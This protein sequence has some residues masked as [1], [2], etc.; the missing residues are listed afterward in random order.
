[1]LGQ[2]GGGNPQAGRDLAEAHA[3]GQGQPDYFSDLAHGNVGPGHRHLLGSRGGLSETECRGPPISSNQRYADLAP[4]V[5]GND[6]K[7]CTE[8]PEPV[9]GINRNG[10]TE[11]TGTVSPGQPAGRDSRDRVRRSC[12]SRGDDKRQSA[13]L[14]RAPGVAL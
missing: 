9:Y 12:R 13:Y 3:F 2:G 5:Y 6:R 8:T 1:M 10:C 7:G 14:S 4:Q 11:T